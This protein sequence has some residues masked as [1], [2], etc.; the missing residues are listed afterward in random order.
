MGWKQGII[1]LDKV[2]LPTVIQ[3]LE[4]WYGFKIHI[5]NQQKTGDWNYSGRFQNE[6]LENVLSTMGHVKGFNHKIDNKTVTIIFN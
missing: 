6:S 2:G 3:E 5:Q 1:V 4:R